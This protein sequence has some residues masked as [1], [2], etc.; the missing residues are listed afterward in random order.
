MMESLPSEQ[1][2]T[3]P[4]EQT[5]IRPGLDLAGVEPA[6]VLEEYHRY[7]YASRF[8]RNRRVLDVACGAG[9]GAALVS[10]NAE[11]VVA[12]NVDESAVNRA[13]QAYG[14]FQNLRFETG[15][16]EE[17][18]LHASSADIAI[19]FDVL[20]SLQADVRP[21]LMEEVKRAL[22]PGGMALVSVPIRS[23]DAVADDGSIGASLPPFSG[24]ELFEFLKLHFQHVRFIA[25]KPL[26]L[27]AMW[28]LHEW[29]DDLFRFH[30]RDDLFTLP[31]SVEMFT[32]P[33]RIVAL[34]SEDPISN[35]ITNNSKSVY[36]DITQTVR[37]RKIVQEMEDLQKQL[38][39]ARSYGTQASEE[40][41][42]FR[43]AIA[44]L[45][46]ENLGY[47][48]KLEDAQRELD[49]QVAK[50]IVLE[51]DLAGRSAA[52]E[53]L[54]RTHDEQTVWAEK[55][56][57]DHSTLLERVQELE[58]RL[59]EV[60]LHAAASGEE[61]VGLRE[62]TQ[63]LHRK[64]EELSAQLAEATVAADAL[65][66]KLEDAERRYQRALESSSESGAAIEFLNAQVNELQAGLE[67]KI[68]MSVELTARLAEREGRVAELEQQVMSTA[69]S[70][71]ERE[72]ETASLRARV[73]EFESEHAVETS[74]SA[75]T[76]QDNQKLR[77]R[78]YELQKQYDERASAARS[79]GQENEKLNA[80]IASMQKSAEEKSAAIVLLNEELAGLKE[81]L[82]HHEHDSENKLQQAHQWEQANRKRL[83][84]M[85]ELQRKCE[86]QA[87]T[88]RQMK[89][90]AEKQAIAFDTFLK[91]QG[92][93]QQR[94]NRSQIRVQELQ[95]EMAIVEQRI[96]QITGSG[97]MKAL[98]R[99]GLLPREGK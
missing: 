11:S 25:Q 73:Q 93:L 76:V 45:T 50:A 71:Q 97:V 61:N 24:V 83:E 59:E 53:E 85:N 5:V 43:A 16:Y 78:L 69:V 26:T 99:M 72:E 2:Q 12:I 28:S 35:E 65:R 30:M 22:V 41:D 32:E 51:Q 81:K 92:D 29:Q 52:Y 37:A 23:A 62:R 60:S 7:L 27:S 46:N 8:T 10:I 40:R 77:A 1:Q 54:R 67:E 70:A 94:Y 17:L 66:P 4:A 6:H 68:R 20:G 56:G 89:N 15:R 48:N 3:A 39:Q 98:S 47:I 14:E 80:R 88:I 19:C 58:R 87:V 38:S 95:Q 79:A 55:L 82:Q 74:Q 57:Q 64:V 49:E 9:Y 75:A 96:Q 63:L 42:T 90:D 86:E 33:E 31:R 91:S 36:F 18:R 84:A 44:V 13:S 21:K 34:C